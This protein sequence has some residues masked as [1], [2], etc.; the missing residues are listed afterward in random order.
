VGSTPRSLPG[1]ARNAGW[2]GPV[3]RPLQDCGLAVST[4]TVGRV[5][6]EARVRPHKARGWLNRA[7]DPL[8][9]LRAGQVCRLYLDRR[10]ALC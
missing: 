8:F 6:A 7:D 4:A 3:S 1:G 5:L 10:R 2:P 9:W